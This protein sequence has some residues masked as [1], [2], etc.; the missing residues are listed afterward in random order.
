MVQKRAEEKEKRRI[1]LKEIRKA[2]KQN[3]VAKGL[4]L[5]VSC[6]DSRQPCRPS[7]YFI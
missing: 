3:K 5:E 6:T 2:S 4:T 1:E 7:E